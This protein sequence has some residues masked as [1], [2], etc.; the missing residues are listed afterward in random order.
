MLFDF[1]G[2]QGYFVRYRGGSDTTAKHRFCGAPP[3]DFPAC[4]NCRLPLLHFLTVDLSDNRL[5][6]KWGNGETSFVY[7]W[8]CQLAQEDFYYRQAGSTIQILMYGAGPPSSTF[9]YP[10]YPIAFPQAAAVLEPIS[11]AHQNIIREANARTVFPWDLPGDLAKLCE[12]QHQLGGEPYLVQGNADESIIC[13]ECNRQMEFLLSVADDCLDDR[14][15]SG[16][17]SVQVLYFV[18][19]NCS[20]VRA[21]HEID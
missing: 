2:D 1:F 9:P 6:I 10:E 12:P 18:C 13:L 7:C 21:L 17:S 16:S 19:S 4:P 20:V 5:D 14:G 3:T 8:R 15:F 11:E